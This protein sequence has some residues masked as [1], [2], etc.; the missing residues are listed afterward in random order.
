MPDLTG[1]CGHRPT[2]RPH[3]PEAAGHPP[4]R[5]CRLVRGVSTPRLDEALRTARRQGAATVRVTGRTDRGG[6]A[7]P[8][9]AVS[10]CREAVP[11][12]WDDIVSRLGTG[13][14][15]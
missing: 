1:R 4:E 15:E 7:D 10:G 8:W 5:F 9:E 3:R 11:G 6:R 2:R 12:C 14:S 13:V